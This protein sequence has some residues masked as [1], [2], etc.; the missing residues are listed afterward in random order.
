MELKKFRLGGAIAVLTLFTATLVA[1][2]VPGTSDGGADG[3][4][5]KLGVLAPI[6]GPVSADGIQMQR[7]AEMIVERLNESG[8]ING[9]EVELE[10]FDVQDQS[11]DAV[12][13]AVTRITSDDDIAAAFTGYASGTNFEIDQFAESGIPYILGGNSA[14]TQEI[15]SKS[16]EDYELTWSVAPSYEGYNT[17]LPARLDQWDE[18]G[19]FELRNRVAY[20][21][22]NDNPFSNSIAEGL[23]ENLK[24]RGWEIVG[25]DVV[26]F[27]EIDDWN[28]QLARIH[29]ADPSLILNIDHLVSNSAKFVK[30]FTQNPTDSLLFS[31]YAPSVPEFLD[32]TGD[33]ADGVIYNIAIE[34]LP[35]VEY[36]DTV[37]EEYKD[38]YGETAGLYTVALFEQI[39]L[40]AIAAEE[41]GD[42]TDRQ[43]VGE[44]FGQLSEE[45]AFGLVQ[46]DQDTHLALA[47]DD[48]IPTTS[49]QFQDG[50][51]KILAPE[52]LAQAEFQ[53]PSWMN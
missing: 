38:R 24:A 25:P 11:A 53:E 6:T 46:F 17:D 13:A 27:G 49:F 50:E 33:A 39:R 10:V 14:Q 23:S 45:S 31:Q 4:T 8:G 41:A 15:V 5:V 21:I 47:G 20:V 52:Q 18:D 37:K 12:A 51:R 44:A 19:T 3:D 30:Q 9:Q 26:P 43:A 48:Y 16:P 22:S 42:A 40:W 36:A 35:D 29:K 28:A 7:G 32:L 1:C 2:S 34:P